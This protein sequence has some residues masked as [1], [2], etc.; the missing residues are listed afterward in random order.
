[1][2]DLSIDEARRAKAKHLAERIIDLD[3]VVMSVSERIVEIVEENLEKLGDEKIRRTSKDVIS[4]LKTASDTLRNAHYN[5][6]LS[7]DKA[8][9]IIDTNS[10]VNINDTD[11]NERIR[12]EYDH[13]FTGVKEDKSVR[14][15][16]LSQTMDGAKSPQDS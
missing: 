1:M 15:G 11:E 14:K 10:E 8:T 6:R 7:G 12:K 5:I 13:F 16:K 4:V 3:E 2:V 9:G